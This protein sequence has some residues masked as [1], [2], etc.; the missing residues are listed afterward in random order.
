MVANGSQ[1]RVG[2]HRQ[3]RKKNVGELPHI[4]AGT[5]D[6]P[7]QR[8]NITPGAAWK[9]VGDS[10]PSTPPSFRRPPLP[11]G[12]YRRRHQGPSTRVRW[13]S[14]EDPAGSPQRRADP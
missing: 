2:G 11:L 9:Q 6:L 13:G 1:K 8:L 5:N 4:K 3:R 10:L 12:D 7:E 14:I